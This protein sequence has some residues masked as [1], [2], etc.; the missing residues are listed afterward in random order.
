MMGEKTNKEGTHDKADRGFRLEAHH[1]R[2]PAMSKLPIVFMV[3]G[4][5]SLGGYLLLMYFRGIRKPIAIGFH[6]ILGIGA[7]EMMVLLLKDLSDDTTPNRIGNVAI[8]LLALAAFVGLIMP[9]LGR[10]SRT[11][12]NSL[13]A[14]H[15]CFGAAGVVSALL[16][17]LR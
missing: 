9:I 3:I 12:A 6:L 11:W 7:L 8:A 13:L 15:G 10:R 17:A 1:R 14:V 5:A 2:R 16:W 4:A